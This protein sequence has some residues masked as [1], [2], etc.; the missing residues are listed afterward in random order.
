MAFNP[1]F[2][3][4]VKRHT[5]N[6][7]II[8]ITLIIIK[9]LN[10]NIKKEI[11]KLNAKKDEQIKKSEILSDIKKSYDKLESY[12]NLLHSY[13]GAQVISQLS[14]LASESDAQVSSIRPESERTQEDYSELPFELV[15]RVK[16][17]HELGRFIANIESNKNVFIIN[18]VNVNLNVQD[19][20]IE[21]NLKLSYIKFKE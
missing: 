5:L 21:A 8:I 3:Y 12:K 20:I 4:K 7:I 18:R 13:D 2:L 10:G 15:V 9:N 1:S 6:I 19:D 16:G 17:Y 11:K 14:Q